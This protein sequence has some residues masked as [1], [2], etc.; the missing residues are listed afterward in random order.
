[1]SDEK[2]ASGEHTCPARED[3]GNCTEV[4][5]MRLRIAQLEHDVTFY[6]DRENHFAKA[7]QVA[8]GGQYRNDWDSAIQ[9]LI[10][11]KKLL[12]KLLKELMAVAPTTA[13]VEGV[14]EDIKKAG[15]K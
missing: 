5:R 8:D 13:E 11:S 14:L 12:L 2:P 1:M 9:H 15:I 6:K 7:L 3:D 10:D 4:E